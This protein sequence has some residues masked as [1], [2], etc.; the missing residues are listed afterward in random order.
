MYAIIYWDTD[1]TVFPVLN[2]D[3][4]LKLFNSLREADDYANGLEPNDY[5]RVISIEGGKRVMK[6]IKGGIQCQGTE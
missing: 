1:S 2:E 5:Y 4:T 3:G 6:R